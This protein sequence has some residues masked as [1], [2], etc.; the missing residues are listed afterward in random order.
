M[1]EHRAS[2]VQPG[3]PDGR[4]VLF[5]FQAGQAHGQGT[6][7]EGQENRKGKRRAERRGKKDEGEYRS[8]LV[9]CEEGGCGH[10]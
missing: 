10:P 6:P 9:R 5:T 2:S 4:A 1:A 8:R 7:G 3:R